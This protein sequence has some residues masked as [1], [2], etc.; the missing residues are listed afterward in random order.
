[1]TDVV[2]EVGPGGHFLKAKAT[3]RFIRGGEFYA[4]RLMPRE[5]YDAW[6][7]DRVTEVERATAAVEEILS[8]HRPPPLPPA[9]E[10]VFSDVVTAA[11][12]RL[13]PR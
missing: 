6:S 12:G 1:M 13:A 10:Q 4:P 5:P 11:E 9:A 3:R 7:V 2:A 8:E